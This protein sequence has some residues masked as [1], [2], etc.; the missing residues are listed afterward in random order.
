MARSL[1]DGSAFVPSKVFIAH[2]YGSQHM[3][4][5]MLNQALL[6][7]RILNACSIFCAMDT[8]F[9]VSAE[10]SLCGVA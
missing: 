10:E 8:L 3:V 9:S 7:S 4:Y 5:S 6:R 2:A 1:S